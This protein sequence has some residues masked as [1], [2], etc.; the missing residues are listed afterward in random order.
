M[1]STYILLIPTTRMTQAANECQPDFH[2]TN[3]YS[4]TD[5]SGPACRGEDHKCQG[6]TC[7]TFRPASSTFQKWAGSSGVDI[8]AEEPLKDCLKNG[9]C[10]QAHF[11]DTVFSMTDK[12]NSKPYLT[13]NKLRRQLCYPMPKIVGDPKIKG[14]DKIGMKVCSTLKECDEPEICL[15][16]AR[17]V[18]D[19]TENKF[20]TGFMEKP[21]FLKK[22]SIVKNKQTV[23]KKKFRKNK[24]DMAKYEM[25]VSITCKRFNSTN[26][27]ISAGKGVCFQANLFCATGLRAFQPKFSSN[28][29][30]LCGRYAEAKTSN[31][32]DICCRECSLAI[33]ESRKLPSGFNATGSGRSCVTSENCGFA[34]FCDKTTN[35]FNGLGAIDDSGD[36]KTALRFCYPVPIEY[37]FVDAKNEKRVCASDIECS[38]HGTCRTIKVML[39]S[40]KPRIDPT[41]KATTTSKSPPFVTSHPKEVT[42]NLP[43]DSS[44]PGKDK[45]IEELTILEKECRK[46]LANIGFLV[47]I[48]VEEKDNPIEKVIYDPSDNEQFEVGTEIDEIEAASS[49]VASVQGTTG[50]KTPMEMKAQNHFAPNSKD[51]VAKK[52]TPGLNIYHGNSSSKERLDSLST[53]TKK[54]QRQASSRPQ[55]SRRDR[56]H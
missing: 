6:K 12:M 27:F 16:L 10:D 36:N 24:K 45:L 11:C 15:P 30:A 47:Q 53:L 32:I 34:E 33:R 17:D 40:P 18:Y 21:R 1:N 19:S 46:K 39:G 41:T 3:L 38:P 35:I 13:N 42:P 52:S 29:Q 20:H 26:G 54:G 28:G 22:E 56:S 50:K 5:P 31:S 51:S 14:V 43:V 48:E 23:R 4:C 7:C 8:T 25:W 49:T 44:D 55:S 37:F 9:D 2:I